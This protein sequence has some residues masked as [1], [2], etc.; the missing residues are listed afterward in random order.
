MNFDVWPGV[1]GGGFIREK[2]NATHPLCPLGFDYSQ[3][4]RPSVES[5][6][7]SPGVGEELARGLHFHSDGQKPSRLDQFGM[8]TKLQFG[9]TNFDL[10]PGV[11]GGSG[12]SGK[13]YFPFIRWQRILL[14]KCCNITSKK[15]FCS[16][17]RYQR[18]KEN[19][20]PRVRVAL[21]GACCSARGV[22]LVVGQEVV[23]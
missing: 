3:H 20:S 22:G 10:W 11:G 17:I 19:S 15:H 21:C 12:P 23:R 7:T 4:S 13:S 1:G 18:M 14:H 5:L 8:L 2:P 16:K 6:G 9:K